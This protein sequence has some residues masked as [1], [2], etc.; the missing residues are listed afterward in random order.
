MVER[1]AFQKRLA[2]K[3]PVGLDEILYPLMQGYDAFALKTDIQIGGTDQTFN[4]QAGRKVMEYFKMRPQNIVTIPLL[5]GNDG[6]KMGKSLKNY[7][8]INSSAKEKYFDLMTIV[9]EIIIDYF[10]LLT[11][12]PMTEVEEMAKLLRTNAINP[13][14]LKMKLA[15]EITEFFHSKKEA[16]EAEQEFKSIVQNK[17]LPKDIREVKA[18]GEIT[19]IEAIIKFGLVQSK[20]E[21]K[22]LI[23][24]GGV[25]VNGT[26]ITN[27]LQKIELAVGTVIKAGKKSFIRISL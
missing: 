5:I 25:E 24:Q 1:D 9:D 23:E 4:M 16:T 3:K 27:Q 6:R 2:D 20:S 10:K 22:R 26:K 15:F 18:S 14:D 17:D 8:A 7:I 19:I 12:V 21:A 11:R 13:R